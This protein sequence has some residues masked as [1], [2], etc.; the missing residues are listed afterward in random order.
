MAGRRRKKTYAAVDRAA[1]W[2]E[3]P[4]IEPANA[5]KRD[6]AGAH[7][8]RLKRDIKVAIS[9]AF[10]TERCGGSTDSGHLG[11]RGRIAI[12]KRAIAGA[13][14][15]AAIM[16]NDAADRDFPTLPRRACFLERRFHE[17]AGHE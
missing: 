11:M 13:G 17:C 14:D 9:K 5:R 8:A 6:S 7:R 1:F 12:G 3:C 2:I 16:H 10:G 15:D 4:V